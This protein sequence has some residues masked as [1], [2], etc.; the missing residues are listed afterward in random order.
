MNDVFH[1]W[2]FVTDSHISKLQHL[3]NR[4][5]GSIKILDERTAVCELHVAFKISYVYDYLNKL[6]RT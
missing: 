1:T 6:Y 2:E 3:R 4:V 5:L